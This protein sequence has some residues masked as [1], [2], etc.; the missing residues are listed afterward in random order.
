MNFMQLKMESKQFPIM[1]TVVLPEGCTLA[2]LHMVIQ[3]A[4]GWLDYH[5]YEFTDAKGRRY[6]DPTDEG[7]ELDDAKPVDATTVT[8][9]K[10]FKKCGDTLDYEYDF[11]DCNELTITFLKRVKV[12]RK[13]GLSSYFESTGPNM[14]EDSR[15]LGGEG[16]VWAI[17][18]GGKK[19]KQYDDVVAWLASAFR[20]A[21]E[22]VL[23][24]P[25]A[26]E[27]EGLV[28]SMVKAACVSGLGG[29]VDMA[30]LLSKRALT[31]NT[32]TR[33]ADE[34]YAEMEKR[35]LRKINKLGI[36][37]QGFGGKCTAIA[38]NIETY[39]TH[40]AGMPCVVNMGCHVTRHATAEI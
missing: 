40:I 23:H 32:D 37:P 6:I 10:V 3:D 38:V 27:I 19:N 31:R 33:N 11:G 16:G 29:T 21:P 4:F 26:T 34:Y 7:S 15:G 25:T 2:F 8:L 30:A 20:L 36:G 13:T 22:Q 12:D 18:S 35:V 9:A 39:P 17:L 5:L 14:V 1:R 24:E 28:F